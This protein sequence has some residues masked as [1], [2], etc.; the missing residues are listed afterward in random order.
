[1]R[2][3]SPGLIKLLESEYKRVMVSSKGQT[4]KG[5]QAKRRRREREREWLQRE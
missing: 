2:P 3:R 5:Q 4:A 1:M